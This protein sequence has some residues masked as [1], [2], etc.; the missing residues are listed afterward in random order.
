MLLLTETG[1]STENEL[2][3]VTLKLYY[4]ISINTIK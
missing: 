4:E 1:T 2:Q 3:L